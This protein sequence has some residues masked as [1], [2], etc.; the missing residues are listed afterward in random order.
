MN[1]SVS[2]TTKT[3]TLSTIIIMTAPFVMLLAVA[4][5]N[6][7]NKEVIPNSD[8]EEAFELIKRGVALI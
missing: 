4:H 7:K 2:E 8:I 6:D 3:T 1:V 5:I